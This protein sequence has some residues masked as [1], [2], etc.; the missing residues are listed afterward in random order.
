[1]EQD[2]KKKKSTLRNVATASAST[3]VVNR[4]GSADAEFLKG[5][6]GVDNE[7]GTIATR[8]L[9]GISKSKL[10]PEYVDKNIKQQAGNSA[11]VAKVARDNAR[12][13][14]DGKRERII[15]TDDHPDFGINDPVYDHVKILDGHIIDGSG[16]QMKFVSSTET[17]LQKIAKGEGG[18]KNDLS[19]YQKVKIDLPSDDVAKAR[20]FCKQE[21]SSLR[22]QAARLE[23]NGNLDLAGKKKAQ[24]ANFDDLY[25]NVRDSG[26]TKE[27]AI[28]Y[29][30]HP[31]I[32]TARDIVKTSH[33]AGCQGAKYGAV[34]GG[35]I[36]IFQNI[37]AVAQDDK[38]LEEALRDVAISTGK[39]AGIGYG[40]GFVGSAIKGG[41]QQSKRN[42]L[43]AL[44]KTSLPTMVVVTTIEISTVVASYVKGEIDGTEFF[45]ELGEKGTGMLASGMG[46]TIG[47]LAIPIPVVG[48]VIGGMIGYTLSSIF[49]AEALN[50]FKGKN[51]AEANYERVKD[52]C[53]AARAEM[54]AYREEMTVVFQKQ[55]G[56][57]QQFFEMSLSE[58]DRAVEL[59]DID[60][61]AVCANRFADG[62]GK[63]LCYGTFCEFDDAMLSKDSVTI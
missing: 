26:L 62:I 53:R 48:A 23:K 14:I 34:I 4:F 54:D 1:M 25:D 47:Q 21:A 46:A 15:R 55:L 49:Y 29:R 61:F 5:Y 59:G 12:N 60:Q 42:S 36:S 27:Q 3:E 6:R 35:S 57:S 2:K 43:R 7:S 30:K 44:S 24:A 37:I 39:A 41:L 40:T 63:T 22:E 56:E 9:K 17:L 58:L 45:E 38:D 8:S 51:E 50:A 31:E 18:G 33:G 32:A 11:E 10:H 52:I 20:Q 13:I 28:F 16:S 19:R